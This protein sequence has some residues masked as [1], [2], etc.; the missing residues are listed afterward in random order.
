MQTRPLE[1]GMLRVFRLYAW[2]L[3]ASK[4]IIPL[5][6]LREQHEL[7]FAF[8]QVS[9]NDLTAPI[10][11]VLLHMGILFALL[12]WSW[13]Q[14]KLGRWTIPAA[15]TIS[16]T[17]LI[18]EQQL[19]NS[20]GLFWQV[21]PFL[22]ILLIL[23][24][25]QYSFRQV[26][27]F[28]LLTMLLMVGMD[29]LF[30]AQFFLT[31]NNPERQRIPFLGFL[32]SLP[33][34]FLLLGYVVNQLVKAQRK[35][36]QEL[37]E[38]NQKLVSHAAT[39]EQLTVSR[40]RMRLSRELHDTLA[41]TLSAM[42]VQIEA[43]LTLADEMPPKARAILEQMQAETS[44]GLGETRRA[45]SALRASPLED[46]GLGPSLKVL[47]QDFA[48]RNGLE[49]NMEINEG[50]DGLPLE[51][52]TSFYRVAQEALENVARHAHA[53][54]L[55]VKLVETRGEGD[56]ETRR[57]GDAGT[58]NDE[59]QGS[60]PMLTLIISDNGEGFNQEQLNSSQKFGLVGMKERAE[61]IDARLEIISRTGQGTCVQMEWEAPK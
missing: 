10:I 39:V 52:E 19:F 44:S 3:L 27:L 5:H 30:P 48:S 6:L 33:V 23:T 56:T 55:E 32:F 59:M 17:G 37:A 1:P 47:V 45:L 54:K 50:A 31:L 15:I 2:L 18:L 11:I 38:A 24:A 21:Y 7:I 41:H 25:W 28:T 51:V 60:Q 13:L 29:F 58:R 8:Q 42:A 14:E 12:Y 22:M 57:G 49:L 26:V 61:L 35:Q 34:T 9:G 53:S 46:L 43:T 40:E 16:A 36:R 4:A 20:R